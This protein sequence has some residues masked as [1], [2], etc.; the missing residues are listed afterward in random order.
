V[1]AEVLVDQPFPGA[2]T[3]SVSGEVDL[4]ESDEFRDAVLASVGPLTTTVVLDLTAVTFFGSS[5][6]SALIAARQLLLEDGRPLCVDDCSDVVE[7]V[8]EATG[9]REHLPRS[10]TVP[11]GD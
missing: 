11:V 8:L 3:V 5:G 4:I 2:V 9:L 10:T 6:I 1:F 7:R